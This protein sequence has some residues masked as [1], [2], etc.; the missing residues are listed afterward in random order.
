MISIEEVALAGEF[1][2]E[3][4]LELKLRG[5]VAGEQVWVPMSIK[6]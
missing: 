1:C 6:G 2:D 5:E 4:G 3:S